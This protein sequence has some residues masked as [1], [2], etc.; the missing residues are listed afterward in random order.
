MLHF[1]YY[2]CQDPWRGLAG[3]PLLISMI[4]A[5]PNRLILRAFTLPIPEEP[6][7]PACLTS[8][9]VYLLATPTL[10]ER[11][12]GPCLLLPPHKSC[13]VRCQD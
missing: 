1:S 5:A 6:R 7:A 11:E 10:L 2:A 4:V 9:A 13:V 8:L 3:S 12:I